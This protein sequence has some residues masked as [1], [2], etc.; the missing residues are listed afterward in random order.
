MTK[1]DGSATNE[2]R[3]HWRAL[4]G[5]TVAASI[6]TIGLHAYTSGA[7][8]PALIDSAGYS[9]EQLSL[10]TLIL[11]AVVAVS[12]PFAGMLMDRHGA[13]RVITIAVLGEAMMF[14]LLSVAPARFPIY[15][16]LIVLLA[17][18]GVGTTPPGFARIVTARF[19]RG[20]GLALGCMISGLGV[21]AISGPIWATWVIGHAG[22]RAGYAVIAGLVLILGGL[23]LMLI[24]GD[25]SEMAQ[26][27]AHEQPSTGGARNAF[28][29]PLFWM[30][31]AGFLLPSLFG[32][33]YLLHLISILRERGFSPSGAAQVQSLIGVAV[34]CGRL[35]SG[36]ALD[37]FSPR[38]VAA[39]AF[40]I[41]ALGCA[42]LLLSTPLLM[43]IAALAI[44]LTIGAEL[45]IMAYFISRY[46]GLANF[47]R[48]YGFAYGGLI[49][50]G[51]VSPLL[52]TKVAECGGGYPLA[53]VVSTIGTLAGA[54]ILLAMPDPRSATASG[55][56]AVHD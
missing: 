49:L 17:L 35:G 34:L 38:W 45:D 43:A 25:R 24:R 37:R 12:A 48:L 7:F 26:A 56:P 18:A 8:M 6:G 5:C 11:S 39:L 30:L 53:L 31:L 23:G 15:A 14:G 42:L 4:L 36:A 47:G 44:G 28:A 50:A 52:I 21:M 27:G 10:A 2:F 54:A 22:W 3:A 13:V 40:T 51:G 29:Q 41:S 16:A 9:R 19:D 1:S 55:L 46:F 33:G 32:G 20:R